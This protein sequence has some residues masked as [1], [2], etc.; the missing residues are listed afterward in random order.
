M[1]VSGAALSRVYYDELVGPAVAARWP[2]LP[3]AAGRLGSGSDVLGFDDAV[4]RDHGLGASSER[5]GASRRG[6][7][8]R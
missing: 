5:P 3:Y 2:S 4:S 7:A 8:G 1:D 6:R